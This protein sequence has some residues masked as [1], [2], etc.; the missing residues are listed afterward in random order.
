MISAISWGWIWKE[1]IASRL[2][3]MVEKAV[4]S[5]R[6]V[7]FN[8]AKRWQQ[9]YDM[10]STLPHFSILVCQFVFANSN[11]VYGST[12]SL[13]INYQYQNGRPPFLRVFENELYISILPP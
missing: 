12:R 9:N 5:H 11:E 3:D 1:P 2:S 4:V 8:C 13:S 10:K 6:Y 7:V